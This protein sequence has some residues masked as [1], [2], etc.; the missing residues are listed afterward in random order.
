[1][2]KFDEIDEFLEVEAIDSPIIQR[3][4]KKGEIKKKKM[5][6]QSTMNI[7]EVIYIL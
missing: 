1:M 2:S 7:Q 6:K 3:H 4:Q 5:M